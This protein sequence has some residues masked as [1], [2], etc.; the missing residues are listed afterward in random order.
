ML[1]QDDRHPACDNWAMLKPCHSSKKTTICTAANGGK[2]QRLL[3]GHSISAHKQL[4]GQKHHR[5]TP[6]GIEPRTDPNDHV[7]D[8]LNNDL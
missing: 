6:V 4:M 5:D 3:S 2:R 1:S 7:S 8:L